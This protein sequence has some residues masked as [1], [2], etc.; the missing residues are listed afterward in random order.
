[1]E[2]NEGPGLQHLALKTDDIFHTITKM[3]IAE[4]E[5]GGFELMSRPS[6]QYYAELPSR[7]GDQLTVCHF[8]I[9]NTVFYNFL[10]FQNHISLL[11]YFLMEIFVFTSRRNN[12]KKLNHLV[13]L[14]TLMMKVYFYK[15]LQN[16]L[17][18]DQ[19]FSLK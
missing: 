11:Q 19:L 4:E 13:F 2:Q 17:A 3:R 9:F 1:M 7:L 16:Q 12:I 6:D 18:T 5:L 8:A 14:Q 15:F 10:S